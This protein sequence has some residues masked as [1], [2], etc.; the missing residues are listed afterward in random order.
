MKHGETGHPKVCSCMDDAALDEEGKAEV[1]TQY[2]GE[3]HP[4]RSRG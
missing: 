1:G 3:R 4:G 2:G